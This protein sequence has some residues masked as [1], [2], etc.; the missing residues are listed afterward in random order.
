MM[1]TG[2]LSRLG[3]TCLFVTCIGVLG[4][5]GAAETDG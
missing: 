1:G 2:I 4:A 3:W 5:C